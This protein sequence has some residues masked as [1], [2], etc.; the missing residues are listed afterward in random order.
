MNTLSATFLD[1]INTTSEWLSKLY[2]LPGYVLV[3][4][5]CL[6]IG[7]MLKQSRFP[8]D[9]IPVAVFLCGISLNMLIADPMA[10]N[11]TIRVWLVKNGVIGGII[12]TVAWLAH[13]KVFKR[14]K[15]YMGDTEM[16]SKS[17]SKI[18]P[19]ITPKKKSK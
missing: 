14:F 9:G 17:K 4:L 6:G 7:Y 5:I 11:F 8:N 13:Y 10:D 19:K 1:S 2:G 3:F 15:S 16:F 12:G 18:I